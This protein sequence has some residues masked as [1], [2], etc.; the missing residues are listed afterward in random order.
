MKNLLFVMLAASAAALIGCSPFSKPDLLLEP[1]TL[2]APPPDAEKYGAYFEVDEMFVEVSFFDA[3]SYYST[4]MTKY[5][6]NKQMRILSKEGTKYASIR[7]PRFAT[8]ASKFRLSL[9]DSSGRRIEL[10]SAVLSRQYFDKGIIIFPNVTPGCYL[11]IDMEFVTTQALT[12]F[13]YSFSANI[14]VK[15]SRFTFSSLDSYVY[16]VKTY[17]AVPPSVGSTAATKRHTYKSWTMENYAPLP[18]L[19]HQAPLDI[20]E[21]RVSVVMRSAFSRPVYTSWEGL[22]EEYEKYVLKKS[23][24]ASNTKLGKLADSLTR[25][26]PSALQKGNALLH[27]VQENMSC[28]PSELR[29]INLD[30]VVTSR[31]GNLWEITVV[32]REMLERS[33]I[34]AEIMITRSRDYGGFDPSFVTPRALSIPLVIARIGSVEYVANPFRRGGILGEYPLSFFDLHGLSLTTKTTRALPQ[35]LSRESLAE[36]VF[37]ID[38]SKGGSEPPHTLDAT[39]KG[40]LAYYLRFILLPL[41]SAERKEYFQTM[42]T[43]LGNS[44][45]LDSCVIENIEASSEPLL[46]HIAFHSPGQVVVRGGKKILLLSH[47]FDKNYDGY[48]TSRTEAFWTRHN[49]FLTETVR[50]RT[51]PGKKTVASFV[52]DGISNG[53]FDSRC[54]TVESEG[55]VIFN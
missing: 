14:P 29:A 48:D 15:K 32:L 18:S 7:I 1:A 38:M 5:I 55:E 19:E 34:G 43:S 20:S 45:A 3:G 51:I 23:F 37:S 12:A 46:V 25:N 54:S 39:M 36:Y 52:C 33:G 35:P 30:K 44:N 21:P 9:K 10:D 16:D 26:L 50:I 13:E 6:I 31:T 2:S 22:A 24:F 11:S 47:L 42:L 8:S 27:W 41:S 4:P 17:G 49:Y 53:L 28:E 40:Y